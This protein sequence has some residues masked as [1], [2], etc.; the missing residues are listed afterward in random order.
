MNESPLLTNF[1]EV[2]NN[3]QSLYL[4]ELPDLA[5][6]EIPSAKEIEDSIITIFSTI[7]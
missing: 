1:H 4:R 5:Y 2:W 7:L 3:L 6:Q